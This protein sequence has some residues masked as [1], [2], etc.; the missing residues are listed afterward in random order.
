LNDDLS[1]FGVSEFVSRDVR[2]PGELLLDQLSRDSC[3]NTCR[4][5]QSLSTP[6]PRIRGANR[7]SGRKNAPIAFQEYKTRFLIGQ[8]TER[9]ERY[10]PV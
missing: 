2:L 9:G 10:E 7:P 8:P 4:L 6:Q 1:G 3:R 5:R